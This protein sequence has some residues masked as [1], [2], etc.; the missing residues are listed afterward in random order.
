MDYNHK[1]EPYARAGYASVCKTWHPFFEELNFERLIVDSERLLD[2]DKIVR[3]NKRQRIQDIRHLW[4]RIKLGEY[5]CDA[6]QSVEDA[7]TIQR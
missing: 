7:T 3:G 1:T 5:D 4:L 2:L 6:C